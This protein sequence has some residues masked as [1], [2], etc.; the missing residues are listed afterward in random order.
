MNSCIHSCL[1]GVIS[2]VYT[3]NFY[4]SA[5]CTCTYDSVKNYPAEDIARFYLASASVY[6]Y[7]RFRNG[8]KDV[9]SRLSSVA[10]H[11]H[12]NY[13]VVFVKPQND[14][15]VLVGL[16]SLVRQEKVQRKFPSINNHLGNW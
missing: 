8:N 7:R 5:T 2:G 1:V 10:H 13:D 14:S 12:Y 4:I 3:L 6:G 16:K 11:V 15:S 9:V